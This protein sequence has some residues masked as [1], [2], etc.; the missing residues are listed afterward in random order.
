MKTITPRTLKESQVERP[1]LSIVMPVFNVA[2]FIQET[3]ASILA[4]QGLR[5]EVIAIDDGSADGS[6]EKL[7]A[8]EDTRLTVLAC[9]K[10]VGPSVAR[11]TAAA[12]ARATWLCPF[13]ADDI[14][15]P[16]ILA[17]YFRFVTS[18]PQ[19]FWGYCR[20]VAMDAHRK[21]VWEMRNRF[22]LVHFLQKHTVVHG[23]A[24]I[25]R[26]RF[27]QIDG[28]EAELRTA[29]DYDLFLRLIPFGDPIFY[30]HVGFHY[31]LHDRNISLNCANR[32]RVHERLATSLQD[33]S[34]LAECEPRREILR[35]CLRTIEAFAAARWAEVIQ[36][37][38][39]LLQNN[40]RGFETYHLMIVA[41]QSV[42]QARQALNL[43]LEYLSTRGQNFE[44]AHQEIEQI[45]WCLEQ[46]QI[47]ARIC[48]DDASLR[49][50]SAVA[51]NL[52]KR[53]PIDVAGISRKASPDKWS[54]PL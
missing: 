37:G 33:P 43:L 49:V 41:L 45:R 30:D 15:C 4:Q 3:L 34:V 2:D 19:A 36:H 11:N 6:L 7:T 22:D 24:L 52:P 48:Q 42:G 40:I 23:M 53:S 51:A 10:N 38:M 46:G 47:L 12:K 14:M 8:L 25:R 31:R 50:F 5:F 29:E 26:D 21:S 20:L 39:V 18:Q 44:G 13:D 32:Q 28:Y 27:L 17:P 1:E 16:D 54:S 9:P 35:E